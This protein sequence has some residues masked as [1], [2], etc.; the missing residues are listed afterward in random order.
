M[1]K[2][3]LVGLAAAA[4]LMAGTAAAFEPG[5]VLVRIGMTNVDPK[6]DN[7][8]AAGL[9]VDVDD[10]TQV[11]FTG[12]YFFTSS[13]GL[14][15]LA[16]LPFE[17]DVSLGGTQI[18]SVKHLPPTLSLNYHFNSGGNFIPYIG[19]GVNYTN[20]FDEDENGALG[21]DFSVD[22][23]WGLAVQAGIDM[24]VQENTLIN[25]SVRYA[26]IEGDIDVS[27]LG[28]VGE[29]EIDPLIIT[30]ALGYKF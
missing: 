13:L 8:T 7:G 11:G 10:D 4:S 20:F 23:S 28:T 24:L 19:A 2:E 18:G 16:S 6:Q 27:G 15:L 14:E 5:D 26:E 30:L 21:A 12:E 25:F 22:D 3:V 29:A 1:K 17:H 9:Q